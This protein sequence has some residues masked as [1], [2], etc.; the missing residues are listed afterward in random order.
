MRPRCRAGNGGFPPR[1]GFEPVTDSSIGNCPTIGRACEHC[2]MGTLSA[3]D[4]GLE[5]ESLWA[6]LYGP[7]RVRGAGQFGFFLEIGSEG[8]PP[9][10]VRQDLRNETL[11]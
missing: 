4:S 11:Q 3:P 10:V 7:L 5:P 8:N 1:T 6:L 9:S 2:Y